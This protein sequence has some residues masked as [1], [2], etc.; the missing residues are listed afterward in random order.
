METWVRIAQN[1]GV[2]V[3]ILAFILWKDW[4]KEQREHE[5]EDQLLKRVEKL[6]DFQRTTLTAMVAETTVALDKSTKAMDRLAESSNNF[7][8]KLDARPCLRGE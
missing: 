4:R 6:E 1:F 8:R 2:P 7:A 3:V 5:K